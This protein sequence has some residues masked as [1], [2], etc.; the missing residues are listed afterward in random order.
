MT[1][2][3][4]RP[5]RPYRIPKIFQDY[6]VPTIVDAFLNT[7]PI[8]EAEEM[9][10]QPSATSKATMAIA[11]IKMQGLNR[12]KDAL[13]SS[14]QDTVF[15]MK[16]EDWEVAI[17]NMGFKELL[18]FPFKSE[19]QEEKLVLSWLKPGI[20]LRY[21]TFY[22]DR[23]SAEIYYCWK[24]DE[25]VRKASKFHEMVSSGSG[26]EDGVWKGSHDAREAL[27]FHLHKL[28]TY[29]TFIT[30]WPEK[31]FLWTLHYEDTKIKDYDYKSINAERLA[32]LPFSIGNI[33]HGG[34]LKELISRH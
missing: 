4:K 8:A 17:K 14:N 30:P 12:D 2:S 20:L 15:S 5:K 28:F 19:G 32:M 27:R 25:D 34:K 29:G 26:G 3:K 13:L 1:L 9:T 11:F 22:G 31:P 33:I 7:D 18:T 16:T 23:N 10:G 6:G 24:A 21:D